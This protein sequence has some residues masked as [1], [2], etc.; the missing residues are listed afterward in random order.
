MSMTCNLPRISRKALSYCHVAFDFRVMY[1]ID[2]SDRNHTDKYDP[3]LTVEPRQ[4]KTRLRGFLP[5]PTQT[6][7]FIHTDD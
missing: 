5:G 2:T 1:R 4:E 3:P 7:L 6:G